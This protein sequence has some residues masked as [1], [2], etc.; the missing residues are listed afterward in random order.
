MD[1]YGT[2][3]ENTWCPGCGNFGILNAV[4]KALKLL[5]ERGVTGETIAMTA[6]IGCHG[7]IFDYLKCSGIYCLHGRSMATAQGI[8]LAN[9]ALKVITFAGDGDALGEGLE[10]MIFAA[11]R[12]AD[13]AII[14]HNNG[15]YGL[16]TGQFTPVSER[17]FKGPSTPFGNVEAPLNPMAL[18]L[19]SGATFLA[20]G[21]SGRIDQLADLIAQAVMHPGFA[22]ID[23]LQP[24]VTFNNTY[25]KYNAMSEIYSQPADDY[26]RAMAAAKVSD[27]IPLGILYRVER[28][29]YHEMLYGDHNPV[30]KRQQRD[31]R[32]SRVEAI[33]AG[34]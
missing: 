9:P 18:L 34:A 30:T 10:H 5:G 28:T 24:C 12:N 20:R 7:K 25:E 27:R 17:G 13:I 26:D 6:G 14:V 11:K 32:L 16:T 31:D 4:R 15:V 8:K 22:F 21:Y 3:A 29:P 19:E 2:Y 23:A 1:E 33:L